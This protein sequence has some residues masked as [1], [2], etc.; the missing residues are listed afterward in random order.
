MPVAGRR[1]SADSTRDSKDDRQGDDA[2]NDDA[3]SSR[4]PR[5]TTE[6]LDAHT[7]LVVVPSS[8]T[9]D[10]QD[11]AKATG[12]P[13]VAPVIVDSSDNESYPTGEVT[14]RFNK[15]PTASDLKHVE[16]DSGLRLVRRNEYVDSQVVL[17]PIDPDQIYLPDLCEELQRR[18][19]VEAAWLST[20]SRYS[21][22]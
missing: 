2:S 22:A 19:D 9:A 14:V 5:F 16:K 11:V 20:K 4:S 3:S 15:A 18:D 1:E 6:S 21:K 12:A 7:D 10:W 17:E 8:S 13:W